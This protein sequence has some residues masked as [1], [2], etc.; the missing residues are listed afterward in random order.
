M[1]SV[2][3]TK[4]QFVATHQS[5]R[6]WAR[7]D[8]FADVGLRALTP[9]MASDRSSVTSLLLDCLIKISLFLK[10]IP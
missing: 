2:I 10:K 4:R 3:G 6:Y 7:V 5:G 8:M 9:K 1:L